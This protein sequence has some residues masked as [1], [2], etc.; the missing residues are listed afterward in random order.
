MLISNIS[1]TIFGCLDGIKNFTVY[2]HMNSYNVFPWTFSNWI[3]LSSAIWSFYHLDEDKLT[4]LNACK[5]YKNFGLGAYTYLD[6]AKY[7]I[8][9]NS[10]NTTFTAFL[11]HINL[12]L[13]RVRAPSIEEI[14]SPTDSNLLC[15]GAHMTLYQYPG[16]TW[17]LIFCPIASHPPPHA[18]NTLHFF[19]W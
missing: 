16:T 6:I 15:I 12:I 11:L 5:K 2:C 4:F 3:F 8:F 7:V 19:L 18:S 9:L 1:Y 17:Q 14:L 10:A 13:L